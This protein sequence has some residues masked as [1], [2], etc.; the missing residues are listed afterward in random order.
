MAGLVEPHV[1]G[2]QHGEKGKR[3]EIGLGTT[4]AIGAP[5][6]FLSRILQRDMPMS[7]VTLI[8]FYIAS[9]RQLLRRDGGTLRS[10][11]A[12]CVC[13]SMSRVLL[14]SPS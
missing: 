9:P 4:R 14:L 6:P 1:A 5:S 13:P 2:L 10:S 8:A 12:L 11:W 7:H 3:R